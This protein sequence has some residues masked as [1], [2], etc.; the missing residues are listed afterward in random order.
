MRSLSCLALSAVL[1]LTSALPFASAQEVA[2]A[3][4]APDGALPPPQVLPSPPPPA[5]I[6]V[7]PLTLSQFAASFQ[8]LPGKYEVL[9]VHPKTGC[10]VK[11]CFT[12]PPGCLRGMRV[13][14]HKIVFDYKCQH[15][16]VIRFLHFGKVWVRG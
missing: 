10:P 12:L 16:V 11:V 2:P 8:P 15:D 14:G 4:I 1:G 3:P 7:Q 9:L 13:T 5:V 6:P